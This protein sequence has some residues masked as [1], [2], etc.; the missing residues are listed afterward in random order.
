MAK[1]N[2]WDYI[3]DILTVLAIIGGVIAAI[4][5][6]VFANNV[7]ATQTYLIGSSEVNTD[8]RGLLVT[9]TND[10]IIT[11]DL[12]YKASLGVIIGV[13]IVGPIDI[14][15]GNGPIF[16]QL[17]GSPAAACDLT[18]PGHLTGKL[19]QIEPG[20]LSLMEPIRD[21]RAN[22]MDYELRVFTA[23]AMTGLGAFQSTLPSGGIT[24]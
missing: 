13:A 24:K 14:N 6:A 20:G 23:T 7:G 10:D 17:C 18:L 1:R 21:L 4:L 16:V 3:V 12:Q 22:R 5:A 15:T 8:V 9:D 2:V 11:Y 19:S